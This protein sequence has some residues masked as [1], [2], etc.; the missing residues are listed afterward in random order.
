MALDNFHL[1][2]RMRL[3]RAN[4]ARAGLAASGTA[5]AVRAVEYGSNVILHVV[6]CLS[7]P[8]ASTS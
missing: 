8:S 3:K 4:Q 5:S 6:L 2:V 7:T 1:N